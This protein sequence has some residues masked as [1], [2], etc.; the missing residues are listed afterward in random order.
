[1][2]CSNNPETS[3]PPCEIVQTSANLEF[4]TVQ[5]QK[6]VNLVELQKLKMPQNDVLHVCERWPFDEVID[7]D[8]EGTLSQAF[9]IWSNVI[10]D[11]FGNSPIIAQCATWVYGAVIKFTMLFVN[12]KFYWMFN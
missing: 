11:S 8:G 4:G 7:V 1:M 6:C 9:S 5:V 3:I 2:S 12:G 10:L